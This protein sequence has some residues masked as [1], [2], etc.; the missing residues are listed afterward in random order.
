MLAL[1]AVAVA[2][3]AA[4]GL[5]FHWDNKYTAALP[6][7]YGYNL[8]D[9]EGDQVK[10]L[11]DGWEVY[12]GELL[13]GEDFSL[14]AQEGRYVYIGEQPNFSAWLGTP[15]GTATYRL[16]LKNPSPG[17]VLYLPE[18]LCAGRIYIDGVLVGEQ[19]SLEPYAPLVTDGI[20]PLGEGESTEIIIQ[21]A[22]YTHYYSGLY[23]PPA[24]GTLK[25]V[26]GMV[27]VRMMVY[28]VLCLLP[29]FVGLSPL[30]QWLMS[31]DRLK[32]WMGLLS[33]AFALRVAYPF[34]R[35][36]G[37]PNVRVLYA[38]EDVCGNLVL[39]GGIVLAGKLCGMEN[40]SFHRRG[41]LPAAA[42]LC[43]FSLVFP[44]LILPYTPWFIN[45]YGLILFAWKLA[46]GGYLIFL[47]G[48]RLSGQWPLGRY[49]ICAAGVYGLCVAA[50]V[51]SANRFEP[52]RGAWLEEYGG[53]ALVMGLA[54]AMVR[55]GA[56]LSQEN[57][58]LTHHLREEVERKTRDMETLLTERRELLVTLLH[59]VKNPLSAL[60][61]YAEL[62]GSGEGE[63][64]EY[65]Q[66]LV[67]RAEAV[68]DRFRQLQ[69]FSQGERGVLPRERVCL[70]TFLRE[71]HRENQPDIEL[72]GV[73]FTLKCL[74]G[75]LTIQGNRERLRMALENLCFNAL[76]FTPED[77]RITLS[78]KQE[79]ECA[80]I[81]VR[82]TGA[83]IAPE[84]LPH[85][86]ERGFTHRP[87]GSGE[88]LGLYLV[89]TI[90]VEHGG[91][92]SVESKLGEGSVFTLRLPLEHSEE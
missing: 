44:L 73:N 90:A 50:S 19:G 3:L 85:V 56:M 54:W 40:S 7:G 76:S 14:E 24:V 65:L 32:G 66:A 62:A 87:D 35:M 51:V 64:G 48:H 10:F 55:R 33:L 16:V 53:F 75:K 59:D 57:Q 2:A 39:L 63:T 67:Q 25:G 88:G 28:G 36:L 74:P 4:Y 46:T 68:G 22:N 83:G 79:G 47:A 52:I 12:P 70:N 20:Y 72:S 1:L 34:Y 41:A 23:Y 86:F 60:Q 45:V 92:V 42:V 91:S 31:R 81:Q 38:L 21:C 26:W 82:D 8:W 5:L 37:A 27:A 43:L 58:R 29:P 9:G 84:D 77:G 69:E 6:G 89:R 18:L 71:F 78:L 30:G 80:L 49:L 61:G 15:Y 11:I 13:D 17:L